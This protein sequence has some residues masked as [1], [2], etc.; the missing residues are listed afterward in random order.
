MTDF[1]LINAP[2]IQVADNE[3][4][5]RQPLIAVH[6]IRDCDPTLQQRVRGL[7]AALL[8]AVEVD[9]RVAL[10]AA[11]RLGNAILDSA[12][13]QGHSENATDLLQVVVVNVAIE[14][15]FPSTLEAGKS[16]SMR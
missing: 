9:G 13:D 12:L 7:V 1:Q 14:T 4:R 6:D 11:L 16:V 15:G 10:A 3:D 8:E 2:E 5:A